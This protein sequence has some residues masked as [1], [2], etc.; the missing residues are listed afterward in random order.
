MQIVL[1]KI[2][3]LTK[4][5]NN[6]NDLSKLWFSPYYK[7]AHNN[8]SDKSIQAFHRHINISQH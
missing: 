3:V 8:D 2:M 5:Y 6:G 7:I 4:D 1:T